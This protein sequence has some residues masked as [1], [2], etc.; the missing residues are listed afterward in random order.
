MKKVSRR[1]NEKRGWG[2]KL[3]S[4]FNCRL[5]APVR[6]LSLARPPATAI[7]LSIHSWL[8]F[9]RMKCSGTWLRWLMSPRRLESSK[10]SPCAPAAAANF[11]WFAAVAWFIGAG[12]EISR[13]LARTHAH[14]PSAQLHTSRQCRRSGGRTD[15][16]ARSSRWFH[17][18][19]YDRPDG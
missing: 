15:A 12:C 18:R 2:D 4:F 6:S 14:P 5:S 1:G 19:F 9:P 16:C 13:S 7:S 10:I 8:F 11:N 17:F 3:Q